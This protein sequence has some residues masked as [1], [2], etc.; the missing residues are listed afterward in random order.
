ML[1]NDYHMRNLFTSCCGCSLYQN[2]VVL[3]YQ[4]ALNYI[5]THCFKS[6]KGTQRARSEIP[7]TMS[8]QLTLKCV[9][10]KSFLHSEVLKC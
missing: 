10:K 8:R 4:I 3:M 9:A 1:N 2:Q 7:T 6:D 5:C